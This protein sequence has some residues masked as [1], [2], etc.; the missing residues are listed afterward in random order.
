M[1][2]IFIKNARVVSERKIYGG[3][4]LIRNGVIESTDFHG[5]LPRG[6]QIIDAG[7][8]Y[9]SAGFVDIH[10][11]GGGGYDFMDCTKEAFCGIS[12]AHLR[13]GTTTLLPT[14][15]SARFDSIL[16]LIDTYKRFSG[17][18][19]NFCG[20]HLEGPYISPN[21]KGAHNAA[22]LH[23]PT[24]EE[25]EILLSE[26]KNVIKR[27][28]AAPELDGMA[29]FAKK[30]CDCGVMMSLGH[31]D[32]DCETALWAFK[33]GF[34]HVT[35]LY[36]A[37]P[38]V[39]KID[40]TVRAGVIEAAYLDDSVT[41]ELI[42]D[43]KH[44][45]VGAFQLAVKIKGMENTALVTD[46]LRPAGTNAKESWLGE[47]IPENRVI[48]EDGVA[49]L[50]DRSSFAGSIATASTLLEKGVKHY[51]AT[52]A[53]T[54]AMITETPARIMGLKNK[55]KIRPGFDADMVVFDKELKI[56]KVLTG[57]RLAAD[58][59]RILNLRAGI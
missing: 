13:C 51:G 53:D 37:T 34:S 42:A 6:C 49:K 36:S 1:S 24:E 25:T 15:V 8:D 19:P 4:I 57:G 38:S 54:V 40:Q 46:A 33:N 28:T 11:H 30:M 14:A 23:S 5:E 29:D 52:L 45:A 12:E 3:D 59:D 35:H 22:L 44:M 43:G 58:N 7:G 17:L 50:P 55:G 27:I 48:I 32:A 47:K 10:V 21:Q 16:K 18:C 26:G 31:S 9:V 41:V 39:R 56:R 2:D 20:I